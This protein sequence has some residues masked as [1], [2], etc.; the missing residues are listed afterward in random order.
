MLR[1]WLFFIFILNVSGTEPE[2]F[3][4]TTLTTTGRQ[5]A[6]V[7]IGNP[8]RIYALEIDFQADDIVIGLDAKEYADVQQYPRAVSRVYDVVRG[9]DMVSFDETTFYMPVRYAPKAS[10][11]AP[12]TDG[13]LGLS[14]QSRVWR[15]WRSHTLGP[16]HL[17][18]GGRDQV[19]EEVRHAHVPLIACSPLS[20]SVCLFRG[21]IDGEEYD[22]ELFGSAHEFYV[23]QAVY[24]RYR[25]NQQLYDPTR[26][27]LATIEIKVASH[28]SEGDCVGWLNTRG[29]PAVESCDAE[30]DLDITPEM[31]V[32]RRKGDDA[33]QSNTLQLNTAHP[34]RFTIPVSFL[35]HAMI[36]V[37]TEGGRHHLF[38]KPHMTDLDVGAGAIVIWFFLLVG[39]YL[40]YEWA[41]QSR[42]YEFRV[43][44]VSKVRRPTRRTVYVMVTEVLGLFLGLASV[45]WLSRSREILHD[46]PTPERWLLASTPVLAAI[47]LASGVRTVSGNPRRTSPATRIGAHFVRIYAVSAVVLLGLWTIAAQVRLSTLA[48]AGTV[49]FALMLVYTLVRITTLYYVALSVDFRQR[50]V[51]KSGDRVLWTFALLGCV[52]LVVFITAFTV[53]YNVR[54]YFDR[55]FRPY[56]PKTE[57]MSWVFVGLVITWAIVRAVSPRQMLAWATRT[58]E[59]AT[60]TE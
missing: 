51:D 1:L 19:M 38:I 42:E 40:P 48:T 25:E 52:T 13:V 6:H 2:A 49:F 56:T 24:D 18:F 31:Y 21:T 50:V 4:P 33:T 44:G 30:F 57:L 16:G 41:L 22:I 53:T 12:Q 35:R 54:P 8:P 60:K 10:L 46:F 28:A 7:R 47:A 15:F 36:Y 5:V 9:E 23:P 29:F 20:A 55:T 59:S 27:P 39:V 26:T 14:R 17:R 34:N 37:D 58:E 32:S 45:L 3:V 43:D 11:P